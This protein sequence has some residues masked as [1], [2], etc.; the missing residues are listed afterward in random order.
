MA[1]PNHPQ[2]SPVDASSD[3]T[4]LSIR[5]ALDAHGHLRVPASDV[6]PEADLYA[7]GLTSHATVN[8][9]IEI[10]TDLDIEFPDELLTKATFG[11]VRALEHA[12][13]IASAA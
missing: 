9:M 12:V 1:Q 8:V 3:A 2:T 4:V 11:S 13:A 7:I 10:E 5:H 6:A